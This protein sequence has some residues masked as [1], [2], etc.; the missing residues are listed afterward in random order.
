M[1]KI[2]LQSGIF[3]PLRLGTKE[4]LKLWQLTLIPRVRTDPVYLLGPEILVRH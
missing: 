3:N 2:P 1:V 4:L